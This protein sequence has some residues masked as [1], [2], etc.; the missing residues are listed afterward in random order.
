MNRTLTWILGLA[1]VAAA[2]SPSL[3]LITPE[4]DIPKR[5]WPKKVVPYSIGADVDGEEVERAL[6]WWK[7]AGFVF[8]DFNPWLHNR[9][10]S[11]EDGSLTKSSAS[12][13]GRDPNNAATVV[14]VGD[15]AGEG[16]IAH[17]IG[18]ALGLKHEM[19]RHA[20][21]VDSATY[22]L[23]RDDWVS[24][25]WSHIGWDE[26]DNFTKLGTT[27]DENTGKPKG[28]PDKVHQ[29]GPY[30]YQSI[31]HYGSY[32]FGEVAAWK[33]LGNG[34][35][36]T[37]FLRP[38][39]FTKQA[40]VERT[41]VK[42]P[43]QGGGMIAANRSH[44]TAQ[45]LADIDT[46]YSKYAYTCGKM[47]DSTSV[48]VDKSKGTVLFGDKT[49]CSRRTWELGP[50][51]S[52]IPYTDVLVTVSQAP[53]GY[54]SSFPASAFSLKLITPAPGGKTRVITAINPGGNPNKLVLTNTTPLLPGRHTIVFENQSTA[55]VD[56]ALSYE[57]KTA[58]VPIDQF[59]ARPP[60]LRRGNSPA[61]A[62]DLG[63]MDDS[64]LNIT[65]RYDDVTLHHA[66]DV[67][68]FQ[69]SLPKA[70]KYE[71]LCGKANAVGAAGRPIRPGYLAVIVRRKDAYRYART[72]VY[73][74][75]A[76]TGQV[77]GSASDPKQSHYAPYGWGKLGLYVKCPHQSFGADPIVF[78]FENCEGGQQ[79]GVCKRF[80]SQ[81]YAFEVLYVPSHEYYDRDLISA[82]VERLEADTHVLPDPGAPWL[83]KGQVEWFA[84]QG[85]FML[86][87]LSEHMGQG[88]TVL[89]HMEEMMAHGGEEALFVEPG[90]ISAA[91]ELLFTYAGAEPLDDPSFVMSY[92]EQQQ[93]LRRGARQ[94]ELESL[95]QGYALQHELQLVA[96]ADEPSRE[97]DGLAE[98]FVPE[99]WDME[100][101]EMA[102]F[103]AE[104]A[105]E[106]SEVRVTEGYSWAPLQYTLAAGGCGG[107]DLDPGDAGGW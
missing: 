100:S 65:K 83:A 2:S 19:M 7:K 93:E 104:R 47:A 1:L 79:G 89:E 55:F 54:A 99:F 76:A 70:G 66:D 59:D 102:N 85:S 36:C 15:S 30:Q 27:W 13:C 80:R 22:Q 69:V 88:E 92:L 48:L 39:C 11:F 68:Y 87:V 78:S 33:A 60:Q 6:G 64:P 20:A 14:S 97:L 42:S 9:Y 94:L 21:P 103:G 29:E 31:M 74:R 53:S 16:H 10:V 37:I 41:I 82:A 57:F 4:G 63:T 50:G 5:L 23:D 107:E 61:D 52:F 18:H 77:D 28:V 43:Q 17:E 71:G 34:I 32:D 84:N 35:L 96:P 91:N 40:W 46:L 101:Y 44:L 45:D 81:M 49:G 98:E 51:Q 24:V 75:S 12:Y 67:D 3:A 62:V 72:V 90:E 38:S 105:A 58:A 86:N 106:V 56:V 26:H 25:F 8:V 73:R 95:E